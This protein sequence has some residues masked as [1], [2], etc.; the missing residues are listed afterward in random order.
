MTEAEFRQKRRQKFLTEK[1]FELNNTTLK[2]FVAGG[3]EALPSRKESGDLDSF[4]EGGVFKDE[5]KL[6]R[7]H[8]TA[9]APMESLRPLFAVVMKWFVEWHRAENKYSVDLAKRRG[10]D[11]RL[12]M[13]PLMF[14][15][16]GHFQLALDVVSLGILLG[17]GDSVR[18]AASLMNSARGTDM[19]LEY[20]LEKI[21]PDPRDIEVFFHEKPYG[22]LV[23]A[24]YTADTPEESSAYVKKYL[25]GWYKAFEGQPWH[26]GHLVVTDEYSNYEGY[27]AF[28]AAA[29]CVIH[30][31]DDTSFRDHLVYPKD[32]A[33]WARANQS[34]ARLKP[35]AVVEQDEGA[36]RLRCE[37]GKPCPR[38]GWW[39]TPAKPD[40]RRHFAHGE[41]MPTFSADY[42]AT[43]WQFDEQQS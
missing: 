20:L 37:A 29:V 27:W 9:G 17:D 25:E 16:L 35:G 3:L 11:L 28:E 34:L 22:A 36:A 13:T 12:D 15:D 39:F 23:D 41:V 4:G 19:L 33:D 7:L 32:L 42:G 6:L 31:I 8:Y 1:Y 21:V 26:N 2:L 24:I 5:L 40:S 43:I 14:G 10:E 38:E 18:E 30:G